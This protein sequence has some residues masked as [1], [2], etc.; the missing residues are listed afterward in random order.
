MDVALVVSFSYTSSGSGITLLV[1][2]S[3]IKSEEDD[4]E[5]QENIASHVSAESDEVSRCVGV[6]E[7]L[8]ALHD[9]SLVLEGDHDTELRLTDCIANRPSDEVQR[10]GEGFFRLSSD[11][12]GS[13]VS[14]CS[15]IM[16]SATGLP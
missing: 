5:K 6:A 3:Q 10:H 15:I 12:P 1:E 2:A 9:V 7:N 4:D 8:R 16:I 13:N 11:V 14:T